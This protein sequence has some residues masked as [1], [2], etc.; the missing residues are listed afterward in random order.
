MGAEHEGLRAGLERT[1]VWIAEQLEKQAR[2]E[3]VV[4]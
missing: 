1:Y 2:G 3:A 4:T